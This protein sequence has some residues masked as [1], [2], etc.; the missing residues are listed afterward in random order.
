MLVLMY[1]CRVMCGVRG[2]GYGMWRVGCGVWTREDV[3]RGVRK[4]SAG[5]QQGAYARMYA[6]AYE[7]TCMH[8]YVCALKV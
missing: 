7:H 4:Q 1:I 6:C 8:S 3:K 5:A 2:V